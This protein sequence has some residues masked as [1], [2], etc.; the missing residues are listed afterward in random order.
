MKKKGH[1]RGAPMAQFAPLRG[2]N[3]DGSY[4]GTLARSPKQYTTRKTLDWFCRKYG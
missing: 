4:K 1:K 3:A 2:K